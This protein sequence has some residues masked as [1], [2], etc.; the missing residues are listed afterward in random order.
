MKYKHKR[1][2]I[3]LKELEY[4]VD[5]YDRLTVKE[6]LELMYFNRRKKINASKANKKDIIN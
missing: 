2:I 1:R 5:T 4:I 6:K 3:K